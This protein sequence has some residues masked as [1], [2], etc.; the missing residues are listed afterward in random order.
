MFQLA[1]WGLD[2]CLTALRLFGSS[3]AE[4]GLA[5]NSVSVSDGTFSNEHDLSSDGRVG[6]GVPSQILRI[7]DWIW[8]VSICE[9]KLLVW[10]IVIMLTPT[11]LYCFAGQRFSISQIEELCEN[12]PVSNEELCENLPVSNDQIRHTFVS[13]QRTTDLSKHMD[14]LLILSPDSKS[15]D[16]PFHVP[17]PIQMATFSQFQGFYKFSY[18]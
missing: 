18:S 7:Y 4:Y 15:E 12:L 11:T 13:L 8:K 10:S 5:K 1:D 17:P 6:I 2:D 14:F 3:S 9:N 16:M